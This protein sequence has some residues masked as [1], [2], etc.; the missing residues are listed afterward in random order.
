[1]NLIWFDG[2]INCDAAVLKVDNQTK[3]HKLKIIC[4]LKLSGQITAS[5]SNE[6]TNYNKMPETLDIARMS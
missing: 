2:K 4:E 1:M 3:K 5:T 6:I